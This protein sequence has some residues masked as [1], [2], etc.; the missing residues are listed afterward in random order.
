[1]ITLYLLIKE[2]DYILTRT[3]QAL[4][5]QVWEVVWENSHSW[6]FYLILTSLTQNNLFYYRILV[7]VIIILI[8]V[9]V[10]TTYRCNE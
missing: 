9:N 10:I 8:L 4:H 5:L 2:L 3:L 1:M 7:Y 6:V